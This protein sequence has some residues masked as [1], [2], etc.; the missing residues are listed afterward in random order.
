MIVERRLS[1]CH[2][3]RSEESLQLNACQMKNALQ[4]LP[5]SA[6]G[7]EGVVGAA[8]MSAAT[9]PHPSLPRRGIILLTQNDT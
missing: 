3:E 6:G 9:T 7:G 2:S 8:I 5:S 4:W 1:H